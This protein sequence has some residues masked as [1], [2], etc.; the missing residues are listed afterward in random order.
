MKWF[1]QPKLIEGQTRT[2]KKFLWWPRTFGRDS[3]WLETANIV[4]KVEDLP[5][6]GSGS[7][8]STLTWCEIDFADNRTK[9]IEAMEQSSK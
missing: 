2:V 8:E 3:R 7:W 6:G 4:E 1:E 9:H 5:S